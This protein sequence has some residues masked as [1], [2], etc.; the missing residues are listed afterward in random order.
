[1]YNIGMEHEDKKIILFKDFP[2]SK[3]RIKKWQELLELSAKIFNVPVALIMKVYDQEIEVFVANES[4]D[5][6]YR[7]QERADLGTGLYCETVLKT[8]KQLMVPNALLDEKWKHNPDIKLGMIFYL[9]LPVKFPDGSN[10]GTICILDR[11]QREYQPVYMTLFERFRDF[12]EDELGLLYYLNKQESLVRE[13]SRINTLMM[14]R[15]KRIIELKREVNSA[16]ESSG[17]PPAYSV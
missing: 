5:N 6:P 11:K 2:L 9:G 17:K 12:I 7:M 4:A 13:V 3:D 14:D 16:L 15:E 1:M 8:N 10:F